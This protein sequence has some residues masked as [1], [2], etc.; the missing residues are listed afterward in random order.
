MFS[1]SIFLYLLS[2]KQFWLTIPGNFAGFFKGRMMVWHL[3][4]I[5]LTAV[6]VLSGF[7]WIYY[8]ATRHPGLRAWMW[9]AVIIG[10][11]VPLT[12]PLFLIIVG[13]ILQSAR[14]KLTGWAIGQAALFGSLISSTF[15]AITGRAHPLHHGEENIT[16]ISRV[17]HFGWMRGGVFWG[18]PSSHTTIAFAMALTVFTLFPKRRWLGGAAILYA[19][20]VG[21][22]V[23]MT[24][25]WFSDFVA[26][27]IIGSVIGIVVGKS[28]LGEKHSTPNI[29]LSTPTTTPK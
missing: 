20:Y 5:A 15:K 7:D 18:W 11:L 13:F 17:F 28:F 29:Q 26:G 25:H 9:P 6:L 1:N 21:V 22:G 12:V 14:I 4:A 8:L 27:A 16:D 3:V 2:M 19:V 10:G 24:I 23:S